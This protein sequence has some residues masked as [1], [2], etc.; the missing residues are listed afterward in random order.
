MTLDGS[1]EGGSGSY[2]YRWAVTSGGSVTLSSTTTAMP[3]FTA[4]ATDGT[5]TFTLTVD[6]TVNTA[7][8]TVRVV[9]DSTP[10]TARIAGAATRTVHDGEHGHPGWLQIK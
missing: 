3:T 8:D 5:L 4:P 9:V 2:T 7:T 10:P 6:D 1:A